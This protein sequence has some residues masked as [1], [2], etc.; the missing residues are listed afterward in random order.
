MILDSKNI[1]IIIVVVVSGIIRF[2]LFNSIRF[3]KTHSS[4]KAKNFNS[5]FCSRKKTFHS[6]MMLAVAVSV[7]W[8]SFS[9]FFC[10]IKN[11]TNT[12]THTVWM[13]FFGLFLAIN[14]KSINICVCVCTKHF[15]TSSSS[16]DRI[17]IICLI[18]V[19]K[20]EKKFSKTHINL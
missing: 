12:Q 17:E 7:F 19:P 15:Q 5:R 6:I 13:F 10:L 16:I 4:S 9:I 11:Q 8:L 1:I 18:C 2:C 20:K 14:L 3:L